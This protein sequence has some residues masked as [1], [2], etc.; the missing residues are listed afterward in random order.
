MAT[1]A[2]ARRS[3]DHSDRCAQGVMTQTRRH[4]VHRLAAGHYATSCVAVNKMDLVGLR[5]RRSSSAIDADYRAIRGPARAL[6]TC[7]V[8]PVV[9]AATATTSSTA[10]TR[11]PW[12][13]GPTLMALSGD[14]RRRCRTQRARAVAVSGA[15]REPAERGLSRLLR[16]GRLRHAFASAMRSSCARRGKTQPRR[17][18]SSPATASRSEAFAGAVGHAHAGPTR[19]TSAAATC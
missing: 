19:S 3:G 9:G 18:A 17:R 15:V 10:S 7:N 13:D 16:H 5:R 4:C 14:G 1:G 8:I 11:M 12:Y 2:S 6:P